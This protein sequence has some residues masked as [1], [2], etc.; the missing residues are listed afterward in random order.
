MDFRAPQPIVE[1][2][3]ARADHGVFGYTMD[4]PQLREVLVKRMADRYNWHIQPEDIVFIPGVVAALNTAIRACGE[5]GDNVLI[6]TPV[7]PPFLS[8]PAANRQINNEVPLVYTEQNGILH[9]EID[10]DAFEAAINPST[11]TFLLCHPHNPTGRIWSTDELKQI[12]ELCLEHDIVVVSDEIHCDLV[13]EQ[14]TPMATISPEIAQNTITLMAPSKTYNIP[15]MGFSFAIIQNPELRQRFQMAEM[16]VVP[17]V[18]V[19]GYT[20]ALAAYQY[21]DD[22]LQAVIDYLRSS[23]DLVTEFFQEYLPQ[24]KLTIPQ[25]TYL[26]WLDTR[27]F[28]M[29]VPAQGFEQWIDPF[30][31]RQARVAL[32]KGALFGKPGEGFARLN[33]ATSRS[34]LL[35][36][37]DRMRDAVERYATQK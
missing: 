1:A 36:A 2:I 10:F 13:F 37:L 9:Y 26:T 21:G 4:D 20:A 28:A 31:L 5:P 27:Q 3:K 35:Q 19:M 6:Q 32:N 14:H 12:G 8:A 30:F 22:W 25:G 17:H 29:D 23:R 11:R 15:S 7:Y 24:I 33:F 16:G 18:G 34:L